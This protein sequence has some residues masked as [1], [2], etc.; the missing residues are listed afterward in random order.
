MAYFPVFLSV[1]LIIRNESPRIKDILSKAGEKISEIVADYEL[2]VVDN[3]STDDSAQAL[4]QLCSDGGLPNLQVY[5]LIKEVDRDTAAWVGV[6]NALGDFVSVFDPLQDDLKILPKMLEHAVR[7][8]DVVFA[9]NLTKIPQGLIYKTA[10]AGF[11]RLYKYFNGIHLSKEVPLCRLLSRTV[12]NFVL[13][14]PS[15]ELSYRLLP[16]TGGFSKF[17]LDYTAPVEITEKKSVR[18]ALNR[19]VRLLVSTSR[20]PMRLITSLCLFGSIANVIYSIYV[21]LVSLFR[22]DIAPGWA[23]LS[24]QQS[25]MFFLVS[26]VLL[27]LSEYIMYM[28]SLSSGGPTYHIAKEFTSTKIT[29]Q[30]K[31]NVEDPSELGAF[32]GP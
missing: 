2:I 19:G 14:H 12:V 23:S 24:L 4:Q 25:G 30:E 17:N 18:E 20:V 9:N 1:V 21:L 29:R 26:L 28:V 27:I 5:S 31:L 32:R 7:G 16:A 6:E 15:P 13:R 3:A 11:D 10:Y 8:V 22:D